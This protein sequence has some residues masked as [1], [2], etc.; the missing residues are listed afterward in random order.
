MCFR[1][2]SLSRRALGPSRTL[3]VFCRHLTKVWTA[4]PPRTHCWCEGEARI[5]ISSWR[6]IWD[7]VHTPS[8]KFVSTDIF[9]LVYSKTDFFL[10]YHFV[11]PTQTDKYCCYLWYY[12]MHVHKDC[13]ITYPFPLPHEGHI[14]M[15]FLMQSMEVRMLIAGQISI[16]TS[17][18][19]LNF[20]FLFISCWG[21]QI[22]ALF[23]F[24]FFAWTWISCQYLKCVDETVITVIRCNS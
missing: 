20:L 14:F 18:Y 4:S 19:S 3:H 11:K 13:P 7:Y 16:I 2:T 12:V 10:L 17:H 22:L 21:Y 8:M 5:H 24:R 15:T 9:L 6:K 23:A 1:S